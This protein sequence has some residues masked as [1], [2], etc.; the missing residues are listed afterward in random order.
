MTFGR[1]MVL[2]FFFASVASQSPS[3]IRPAGAFDNAG[4]YRNCL[5]VNKNKT[6][7][8]GVPAWCRRSC[9]YYK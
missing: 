8:E 6:T 5:K 3:L 1:F 7:Q 2:S 9:R 4:C